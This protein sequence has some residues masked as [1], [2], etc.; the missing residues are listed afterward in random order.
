MSYRKLIFPLFVVVA[1]IQLYVPMR[2]ILNREQI[3]REGKTYKFR[4]IPI[5]PIDPFRGKYIRLRFEAQKA[6]VDTTETWERNET[7]FV[8]LSENKEGFAQADSVL[9]LPP[10]SGDYLRAKVR[11]T[12]HNRPFALIKYPF[13]RYYMEE[14]KAATAERISR[15]PIQPDSTQLVYAVVQVTDG[16]SVLS[17]VM[18]D[19]QRIEDLVKEK[20]E[21]E[22][23]ENQ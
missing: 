8:L 21:K 12:V 5:D 17:D 19:G 13:E 7:V 16:E 11:Y 15:R 14:S 4:V 10:P 6:K 20:L 22:H 23:L 1:L 9:K 3:I 2:M 18:V